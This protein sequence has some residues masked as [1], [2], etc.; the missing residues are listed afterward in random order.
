MRK[1]KKK[2]CSSPLLSVLKSRTCWEFHLKSLI[3]LGQYAS[4][5][6]ATE[7]KILSINRKSYRMKDYIEIKGPLLKGTGLRL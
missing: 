7:S 4:L 6:F 2:A 1:T 3:E 5:N